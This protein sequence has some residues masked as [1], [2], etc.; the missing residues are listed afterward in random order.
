RRGAG[1]AARRAQERGPHGAAGAGGA[2]ARTGLPTASRD[3]WMTLDK[4]HPAR[5]GKA[6]I[7]WEAAGR[8]TGI[9]RPQHSERVDTTFESVCMNI[10]VHTLNAKLG[11]DH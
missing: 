8:W 4:G 6:N 9:R 1:Q 10:S 7:C 5:P 11:Y 2:A 3:L